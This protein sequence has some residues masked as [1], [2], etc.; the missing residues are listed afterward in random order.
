MRSL[1]YHV[2]IAY[3]W[4]T[5]L[6]SHAQWTAVFD[7]DAV[8]IE[9]DIKE[10]IHLTLVGLPNEI[11]ANINDKIYVRLISE[12]EHVAIISNQDEIEFTASEGNNEVWEGN[13]EVEGIFLGKTCVS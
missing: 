9:T 4:N 11:I 3:I 10:N 7:P 6:L 2:F 12:Y 1:A 5:F 8:M 13:F